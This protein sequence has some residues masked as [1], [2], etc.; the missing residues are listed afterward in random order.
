MTIIYVGIAWLVGLVVGAMTAGPLWSWLA[1][2]LG[3][4]LMA[5]L[6]RRHPEPRRWLV[7]LAFFCLGA[8]RYES[9]APTIDPD[10]VS[11]YNDTGEVVVIGTVTEEP[12]V[13]DQRV[14]LRL[15]AESIVT[16]DHV[17]PVEGLVLLTTGR[18]PVQPYGTRL[19]LLGELHAPAD[20]P[21]YDIRD[22][23]AREGVFSEM[24]WSDIEVLGQA[25]GSPFYRAIYAIKDRARAVIISQLPEPHAALLTG[26]LLGD[27]SGLP[28]ELAE[29]F[30]TT[31]MTHII[32]I[33]GLIMLIAGGN[34][35]CQ[36]MALVW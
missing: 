28:R 22:R 12:A 31:G 29:Q 3:A 32:A 10:H 21:E 19:Q 35:N 9:A 24:A 17:R 30:R 5:L 2:G 13:R 25:G 18:Y 11:F 4:L 33:S 36:S 1:I 26:I 23:L 8:A 16:A 14:Q 27:D 15:E 7:L 34:L 20:H 6:F